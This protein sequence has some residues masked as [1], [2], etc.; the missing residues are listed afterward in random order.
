[1]PEKLEDTDQ[2][3]RCLT[4]LPHPFVNLVMPREQ[5]ASDY[6]SMLEELEAWASENSAPIGLLLLPGAGLPGRAAWTEERHWT[7]L[8]N[9]PGMWMPLE[10]T[11]GVGTVPE[12]VILRPATETG[13]LKA[14]IDILAEGYPVPVE[15]ADFFMRGI[16][17]AGE[18]HNG[19]LRNFIATAEGEPAA[20]ASVCVKDGVA[21]IY[22]VAT[23][24]RF[25]RRGIGAAITRAAMA[26][27]AEEGARYALLHATP[28]GAPIYSRIGFEER[29]RVPVYGF[30]LE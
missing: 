16:H 15:A 6:R 13:D 21:G 14:V 22:G 25:R 27:G 12:G 17:L 18:E 10:E 11:F 24:E 19:D 5:T 1:M 30:G 9:M 23:L 26:H 28:E 20:C 29:C 3:L 4:G 8:D 2:F 7:L